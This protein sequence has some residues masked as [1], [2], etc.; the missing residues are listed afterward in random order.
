M[1]GVYGTPICGTIYTCYSKCPYR[2]RLGLSLIAHEGVSNKIPALAAT[3]NGIETELANKKEDLT[4]SEA[5]RELLLSVS[6]GLVNDCIAATHAGISEGHGRE[7]WIREAV[8]WGLANEHYH[9]GDIWDGFQ[10]MGAVQVR[11]GIR[12]RVRVRVRVRVKVSR[13]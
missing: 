6:S 3:G 12:R 2:E 8:L 13:G 5:V 7:V 4:S 11:V 1:W 10:P 9:H